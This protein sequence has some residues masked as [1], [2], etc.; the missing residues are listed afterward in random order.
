MR[1]DFSQ[2]NAGQIPALSERGF[3]LVMGS[4]KA[5]FRCW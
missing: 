5:G 3:D 4:I 1:L 2:E